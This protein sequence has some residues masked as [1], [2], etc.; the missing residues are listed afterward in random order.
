MA[1]AALRAPRDSVA[2]SALLG[3]LVGRLEARGYLDA[4]A[5]A[6]W[7]APREGALEIQVLEGPR[8]RLSEV[9]LRT[10]SG[11]DSA[12][13]AGVLGLSVGDWASPRA[14]GSPNAPSACC[15]SALRRCSS[16]PGTGGRCCFG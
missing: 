13:L 4:R 2:L 8:Y 5:T 14:S 7:D 6:T 16:G 15:S 11:A 12:R 1:Q 9:T 10:P 3:E